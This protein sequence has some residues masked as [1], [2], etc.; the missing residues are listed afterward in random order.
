MTQEEKDLMIQRLVELKQ[1]DGWKFIC[2]QLQEN[3]DMLTTD[4]CFG[5]SG[6]TL[7]DVRVKQKQRLAMK[8]LL[9][10]PDEMMVRLKPIE[11][12]KEE[13]LDPYE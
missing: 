4:L 11:E 8:K 12:K 3:V 6:E 5:V 9:D 1:T 7:E 2:E 10:F 13:N